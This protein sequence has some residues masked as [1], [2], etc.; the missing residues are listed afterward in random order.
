LDAAWQ[1]K[2][3]H[4]DV[5]N[6]HYDQL[7]AVRLPGQM[8]WLYQTLDCA[9]RGKLYRCHPVVLRLVEESSGLTVKSKRDLDA[10][11]DAQDVSFEYLPPAVV[12]LDGDGQQELLVRYRRHPAESE[13]TAESLSILNLPDLSN[14]ITPRRIGMFKDKTGTN[15]CAFEF[16]SLH[17]NRDKLKDLRLIDA[18]GC[19]APSSDEVEHDREHGD[20]TPA[21][22]GIDDYLATPKRRFEIITRR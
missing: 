19:D 17:L 9:Q 1:P 21:Y 4:P 12:D 16:Y 2:L 8:G 20:K 15:E 3:A 6:L 13:Y 7:P 18:D 10:S 11:L 14:A 5:R 22:T